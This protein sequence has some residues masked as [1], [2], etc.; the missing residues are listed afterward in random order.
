VGKDN[1]VG[2]LTFTTTNGTSLIDHVLCTGDK[3]NMI[4]KFEIEDPNEYSDHS[5]VR[6]SV[7]FNSVPRNTFTTDCIGKPC[8]VSYIWNPVLS[9]EYKSNI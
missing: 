4:Q 6:F 1:G 5:V 3:M 8:P 7:S 9:N 2:K